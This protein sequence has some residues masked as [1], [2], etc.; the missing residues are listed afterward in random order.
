MRVGVGPAKAGHYVCFMGPA[1]AGHYVCL[2]SVRLSGGPGVG[3]AN[4][5]ER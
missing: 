1:K 4:F 2:S 5:A 3:P